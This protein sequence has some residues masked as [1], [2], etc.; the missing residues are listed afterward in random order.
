MIYLIIFLPERGAKDFTFMAR[1]PSDKQ[2]HYLNPSDNEV[3]GNILG[4]RNPRENKL[5]KSLAS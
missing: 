1:L 5:T 2:D 3:D 4:K